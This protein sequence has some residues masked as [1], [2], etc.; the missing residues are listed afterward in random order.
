MNPAADR[1]KLQFSLRDVASL[2]VVICLWLA[3]FH[4][5][6]SLGVIFTSPLVGA[7]LLLVGIARRLR[8]LAALGALLFLTGPMALGIAFAA[9]NAWR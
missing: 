8:I 3:V 1:P 9:L 6:G 5:W 7:G 2:V 4:Y